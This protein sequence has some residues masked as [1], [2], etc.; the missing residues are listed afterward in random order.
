MIWIYEY[1]LAKYGQIEDKQGQP[2]SSVSTAGKW[3]YALKQEW[4]S[5]RENIMN[6]GF[7]EYSISFNLNVTHFILFI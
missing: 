5:N 1:H 6:Y 3:A 2:Q 7:K 4:S